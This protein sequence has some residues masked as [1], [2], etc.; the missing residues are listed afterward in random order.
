MA[1]RQSAAEQQRMRVERGN[2]GSEET[3]PVLQAPTDNSTFGERLVIL[4]PLQ[5]YRY[6]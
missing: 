1:C 3:S 4:W 5:R 2:G 6:M